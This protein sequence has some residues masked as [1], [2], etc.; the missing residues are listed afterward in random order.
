MVCPHKLYSIL[1]VIADIGVVRFLSPISFALNQPEGVSTRRAAPVC[2]RGS[3]SKGR[4]FE[5]SASA[6]SV[7]A[8]PPPVDWGGCFGVGLCGSASQRLRGLAPSFELTTSA[9]PPV[10]AGQVPCSSTSWTST[11][12]SRLRARPIPFLIIGAQPPRDRRVDVLITAWVE[13]AALTRPFQ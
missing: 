13:L 11:R 6:R 4:G 5:G 9:M 8:V 12:F 10:L 7:R 2:C 3:K 1:G